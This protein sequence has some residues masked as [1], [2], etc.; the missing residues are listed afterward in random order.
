MKHNPKRLKSDKYCRFH[1][2]R[3]HNTEDC[4]HLKNEIEKLIQ[5]GYLKEYVENK[6]SG[7]TFAPRRVG[8]EP[9]EAKS[10]R[11]TGKGKENLPTAGVIGVVTGGPVGGDLA[12]AR[13]AMV[14]TASSSQEVDNYREAVASTYHMKLK[15]LTYRGI[16][17]KKGDHRL[18][19][20]FKANILKKKSNPPT[21]RKTQIL[22]REEKNTGV[23]RDHAL[24]P[25]KQPKQQMKKGRI[26]EAKLAATEELNDVQVVESEPRKTTSIRTAMNRKWKRN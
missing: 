19:R 22:N 21:E 25:L 17:E 2:D 26:E 6:P 14:R 12:C 5:R 3:G 23:T 10:S 7:H 24:P 1:K 8:E 13:K 15:F 9:E 4:Y 20:E 11:R 18:A 16:G